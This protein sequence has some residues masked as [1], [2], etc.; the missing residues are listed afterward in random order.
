MPPTP[1]MQKMRPA[2]SGNA[3][4][5][6][7]A[8]LSMRLPDWVVLVID[9]YPTAKMQWDWLNRKF[10]QPRY[11]D[12][13]TEEGLT[14]EPPT[15]IGQGGSQ[16]RQ[17][18]G[19]CHSCREEGHRPCDCHAL[20]EEPVTPLIA[21]E[22]SGASVQPKTSPAHLTHATDLEGEGCPL[23]E[24]GDTLA[25]IVN[26]EAVPSQ[27]HPEDPTQEVHAQ[28][29]STEPEVI[30]GKPGAI[31]EVAYKHN[32]HVEPDLQGQPGNPNANT[33]KGVT[34]PK[35]D[36]MPGEDIY[37]NTNAPVHLEG[38]GPEVMLEKGGITRENAS[39]EED[40]VPRIK[41]QESGVSHLAMLE[42][43]M[44]LTTSSS[45]SPPTTSKAASMQRSLAA[46]TG[47][48]DIPVPDHGADLEPQ[49]HNTLPLPNEAT[50]PPIHQPPMQIQAPTEVGGPLESLLGK[51]S[52]CVMG[53]IGQTSVWALEGKTP[54]GEVHGCPPDLPDPQ[55]RSSIA[56]EQ[57]VVDPKAHVHVHQVW[58][59][60]IDKS[61]CTCPDLWP[62]LGIVT[63][64]LDIYFRSAL[65]LEGEQNIHLPCV[66][67]KLHAAPCT[68]QTFSFSPLP[69]PPLNTFVHKNLLHGEGVAIELRVTKDYCPEL[70]KPPDLHIEVLEKSGGVL[71]S[72]NSPIILGGLR[73]PDA[74]GLAGVAKNVDMEEVECMDIDMYK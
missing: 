13:S 53:Q 6:V 58:R 33:P 42:E 63:I 55:T 40:R 21:Q 29:A 47:T 60:V 23:A 70:W 61:A 10:G 28:T 39:I 64:D 35:L 22:Q 54:T 3:K 7:Q 11:G 2:K 52:H 59:P 30:L 27:Q 16:R 62:S 8:L 34:H 74:F 50:E 66:G 69:F 68:P 57:G 38:M 44:F 20:R 26:V 5:P 25:Q 17:H 1:Q 12:S 49:L 31:E 45:P 24:E 48:P 65:Q 37:P 14:R 43:D 51:V 41:L 9:S 18:R 72:D 71:A 4:I 56:L 67:S 73:D 19:K 36:L 15:V 32:D 46:N